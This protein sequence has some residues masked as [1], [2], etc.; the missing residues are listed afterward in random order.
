MS[1][2]GNPLVDIRKSIPFQMDG[3]SYCACE[4]DTLA[5]ALLANGVK[6]MGRSF[7]YHR[8][9]GLFSDG[10]EEPNALFEIGEGANQSPNI[11]ATE[12]EVFAGLKARSQNRFPSLD[13]DFMAINDYLSPFLS[14]G[15]YYKTFMWPKAF[16]E[17]IYEPIIRKAAGLG[18]LSGL[19]DRA[20]YERGFLF[21]EALFIGS[22]IAGLYGAWLAGKEGKDV[23]LVEGDFE[24]G[25]RLIRDQ[26]EIDGRSYRD[27]REKILD[28]LRAMPNVRIMTR[29]YVTGVYDGGV[30]GALE[31][32]T[33]HLPE[34][35]KLPRQIFWRIH[36]KLAFN[37]NGATERPIAFANNDRPGIMLAGSVR[38][39]ANR[40]GVLAGKKIAIF[41]NNDDGWKTAHDLAAL[42]APPISVIDSRSDHGMSGDI[43]TISGA[44]VIDTKGRAG[45]KQIILSNGQKIECDCL[46][47]SGGW[48]PN[49]HLMCH[50]NGRPIWNDEIA[51]FIPHGNMIKGIDAIGASA[52]IFDDSGILAQTFEVVKSRLNLKSSAKLPKAS[53][54]K[55]K[56]E[57]LFHVKGNGK[58]RAWLDL[59]NDVTVKDVKLAHQ[60][61]FRSVEHMKRYTTLG[62]ATDQGKTSNVNALA[63]MAE[64]T[65]QSIPQTGTTTFRPP[66]TPVPIGALG[67]GGVGKGFQPERFIPT[68]KINLELGAP[69][70]EAGLWY[71]PS[72]FPHKGE[73]HWRQSCDREVGYVRN[74][75]GVSDVGTLGK[76]DVQGPDAAKFLDL[77]YAGKMSTL[78]LGRIRYGLMLRED[79]IVMDDGTCARLGDNHYLITTTT[80]AAGEVMTHM[81]FVH[82]CLAPELDV[83]FVSVT[84]H[85]AQFA[86]AGPKSR[87]LLEDLLSVDLSNEIL[88]FM[89]V[90]DVD[91]GGVLAKLYRISF[92]GELGFE[93]SVPRRYGENLMR[94][95]I[96]RARALGGGIYGIEAL[97]VLRIEKGFIT[98]AEIHGR[99]TADDVGMGKMI[100]PSKDSIGKVMAAREGLHGDHRPQLVGIRPSA[101]VQKLLAGSLMVEIG[102][103]PIR[104][105]LQGYVTSVCYSPSCG[106]MIGLAFVKNG[107]ARIGE[108]IRAVDLVRDFDTLCEIVEPVFYDK[109]G[110]KLRG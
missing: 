87:E 65:G 32:V 34:Q 1:R 83:R 84:D 109:D 10:I 36:A 47:V 81:E 64:L 69:N 14:A 2:V 27:W 11:R 77:L 97:N 29:T 18:A 62:M 74:A 80:A 95:L 31:R 43:E 91:I 56:L 108:K 44:V 51:A 93:I 86:I 7:K 61:N 26:G 6:I 67:A 73:T 57:P 90:K 79:G 103:E 88:P 20:K 21:C 35:G 50:H 82:Q 99:I 60:E 96:N 37:A 22:G 68:H 107:R 92:S 5:S 72:Y 15:F 42:G 76:I 75:V 78:Q 53:A 46:A 102:D 54:Q 105:N 71:R 66:Y 100:S 89:A 85:F 19:E 38:A 4:G 28:E 9:R 110:E 52:G 94:E 45:L 25:G 63:I 59:Q 101:A 23:I 39:Y 70:I 16:W 3:K 40:F 30:Y 24:L 8:P 33:D 12:Q 49:V 13:R 106:Q 41:T 55:M 98:H 58:G 17:K 104:E 48:N